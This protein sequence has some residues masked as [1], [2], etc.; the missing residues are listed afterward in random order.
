MEVYGTLCFSLLG[1]SFSSLCFSNVL[2]L[3]ILRKRFAQPPSPVPL[4]KCISIGLKVAPVLFSLSWVYALWIGAKAVAKALAQGDFIPLLFLVFSPPL[5][6]FVSW[7]IFRLSL[8]VR[9]REVAELSEEIQRLEAIRAVSDNWSDAWRSREVAALKPRL[10][11][12]PGRINAWLQDWRAKHFQRF[13][14]KA[15]RAVLLLGKPSYHEILSMLE[16]NN[17]EDIKRW[18]LVTGKD[19]PHW[20]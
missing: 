12:E 14:G 5:T 7:I 2:A 3:A 19:I 17:M 20:R 4:Q 6:L 16:K 9:G 8:R 10:T 13:G 11:A 1:M 15:L 18:S